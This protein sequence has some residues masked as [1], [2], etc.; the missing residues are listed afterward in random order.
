MMLL[1][2]NLYLPLPVIHLKVVL[3]LEEAK[4]AQAKEI[5]NLNKRVKQLE[6]R[7]KSRTSGFNRLR[8]VGSASRVESSNDVSLGAQEDASKQERKIAD[9]D[10]DKE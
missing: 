7:R 3:D 6:Q 4:T 1:M 5:A 9:L 2:R 8:K 10:A